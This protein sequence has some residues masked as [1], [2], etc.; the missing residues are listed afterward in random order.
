MPRFTNTLTSVVVNVDD[1]TAAQLGSDWV[2]AG[3]KADPQEPEKKP[4]KRT[5]KTN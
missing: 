4:S 3:G 1:V 5:R 2:P